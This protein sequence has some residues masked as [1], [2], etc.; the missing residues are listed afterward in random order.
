VSC[1]IN[2]FSTRKQVHLVLEPDFIL[3][4]LHRILSNE[5]L[6]LRKLLL[7]LRV[8][9][10]RYRDEYQGTE[11]VN[12]QSDFPTTVELYSAI[13]NDKNPSELAGEL[14]LRDQG[15][16]QN[17]SVQHVLAE[18][19]S[20]KQINTIWRRRSQE[21]EA[22][23]SVSLGY[24]EDLAKASLTPFISTPILTLVVQNAGI[25]CPE[26]FPR[27]HRNPSGRKECWS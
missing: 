24:M 18:D 16:F 4:P 20:I 9:E 23:A 8:L 14:T 3:R 19:G 27:A 1:G 12:W 5:R 10:V 7:I 17:V 26:K 11:R 15:L 22:L 6:V 25:R 21:V 2:T 13:D